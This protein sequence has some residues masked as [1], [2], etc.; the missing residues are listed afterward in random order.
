MSCDCT[1][2]VV[3][4]IPGPQGADGADGNDGTNGVNAFTLTSADFTQPVDNA[5]VTVDVLTSEWAAVG[6]IVFVEGGGFYEVISKPSSTSL[7]LENLALDA[8]SPPTTIVP[9]SS[10]VSPAGEKGEPGAD[11]ASGASSLTT[12]GDIQ[13]YDSAAARIPVGTNGKVLAADS[14]QVLGV[15]YVTVQ[16]NTVVQDN[17]IPRYDGTSGKP[18]P[19]QDSFVVITDDGAIQAS[20]SGGNARGTSAVDLQV[21]RTVATHV[22]SG[23][24]SVVSGG[25]GNTASALNSSVGGGLLNESSNTYATVAG[26]DG[27]VASGV[28]SAVGGGHSNIASG[29]AAVVVGGKNNDATAA[30]S[31]I[32]GGFSARTDL[33]GQVSHANGLFENIGDAQATELIWFGATTDATPTE[34]FLDNTVAR[35]VVRADTSWVFKLLLVGREETTGD[36][37]SWEA[38]GSIKNVGGVPAMTAAATI[39]IIAAD[40]GSIGAGWGLVGQFAISADVANDSLKLAVT[41]AAATNIRWVAH[42]RVVELN[43]IP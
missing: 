7:E 28:S 26:G 9:A 40:A 27:N 11:G 34:L 3:E 42:A 21:Q 4:N 14:A 18:V 37:A 38:K 15:N 41:G 36:T 1:D 30:N 22:A 10:Q 23:Q 20:G 39:A 17:G 32:T 35:A 43:Y 2:P 12:K 6:Q 16:P 31:T 19:L 5:N 29:S 24:E 33:I 8:N 25:K 13:G